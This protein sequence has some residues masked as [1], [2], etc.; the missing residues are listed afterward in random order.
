M[1]RITFYRQQARSCAA[2]ARRLR[3]MS[4]DVTHELWA[5]RA[6]ASLLMM[7]CYI[8]EAVR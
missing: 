6:R 7:R 2:I 3:F 4:N 8:E 1:T 5:E